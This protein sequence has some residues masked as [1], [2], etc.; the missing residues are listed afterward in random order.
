MTTQRQKHNSLL[1]QSDLAICQDSWSCPDCLDSRPWPHFVTGSV[2]FVL[3]LELSGFL[4]TA[5]ISRLAWSGGLL[6]SSVSREHL[7]L[8]VILHDSG[9]KRL[10]VLKNINEALE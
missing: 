8:V 1:C 4:Q 10:T 6:C 7:P 5:K 9:Q 3:V 2:Q